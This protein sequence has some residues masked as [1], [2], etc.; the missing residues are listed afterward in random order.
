MRSLLKEINKFYPEYLE[1][2][3]DKR[4]RTL[5]FIGA[6]CFFLLMIAS[7]VTATWWLILLAILI[8][9]LLPGIGHKYMESNKSFRTSKPLL[10]VLCALRMYIEMW[11]F[12][13]K[14]KNG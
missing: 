13:K 1:A 11:R 3:S 8:G 6:T 14:K 10:C 12:W 2:H 5:H 4:N 9:Y 7:M